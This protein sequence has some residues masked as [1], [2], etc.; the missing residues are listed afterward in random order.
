M[1]IA[2]FLIIWTILVGLFW[3]FFGFGI[4]AQERT[5]AFAA[6]TGTI[7]SDRRTVKV[8]HSRH[9]GG[10]TFGV[11]VHYHYTVDGVEYHSTRLR[12]LQRSSSSEW[13]AGV[14]RR[15]PAGAHPP[16]F[17]DPRAPG[18]STLIQGL[19]GS[20]Y[21]ISIFLTPFTMISIIGLA[22]VIQRR[23]QGQ[24][25]TGLAVDDQSATTRIRPAWFNTLIVGPIA[26]GGAAFSALFVLLFMHGFDPSIAAAVVAWAVIWATAGVATA[27]AIILRQQGRFDLVLDDTTRTLRVRNKRVM[28]Y[29]EIDKIIVD[30]RMG[31]REGTQYTVWLVPRAGEKRLKLAGWLNDENAA[32]R[33]GAWLSARTGAP[34]ETDETREATGAAYVPIVTDAT[35]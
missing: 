8:S 26:L 11:D 33:F 9:G 15:F 21:M 20:D 22:Y 19:E 25:V 28:P 14:L 34:L 3:L 4:F 7:D 6:T 23:R 27:L 30:W 18:E 32:N 12:F 1:K 2:T 5:N 17:Y 16:V 24:G 31:G 29:G 13:A 35:T 10:T